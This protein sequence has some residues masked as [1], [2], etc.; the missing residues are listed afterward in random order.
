MAL[1]H[2]LRK[3]LSPVVSSQSSQ[4]TKLHHEKKANNNNLNGNLPPSST[5]ATIQTNNLLFM[6][7]TAS[8]LQLLKTLCPLCILSLSL[9]NLIAHS[10]VEKNCKSRRV[11]N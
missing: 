9:L 8:T 4:H 6:N 1:G 2:T 11:L 3:L 7:L 10:Q 5:T